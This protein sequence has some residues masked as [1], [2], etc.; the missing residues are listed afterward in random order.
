M[1]AILG[2]MMLGN[3]LILLVVSWFLNVAAGN[4][5]AFMAMLESPENLPLLKV[6]TGIN[7]IMMFIA[8]PIIYLRIFYA[9]KYREVLR[10][11]H[12]NPILL[13]LFPMALIAL[14]PI[15]G[16]L[17]FYMAQLDLPSFLDK[18][19][20]ES[21]ELVSKIITMNGPVDFAF[22]LI[23]VGVL[24]AIGE[25]LLFRGIIQQELAMHWKKNH[26]AIWTTAFIFAA[27]HFQVIGFIP[28]MMIGLILGYA[29][30]Y[31]KSLWLPVFLHFVN[32]SLTL[33]GAYISGAGLNQTEIVEKNIPLT[34]VVISFFI[35]GLLMY[36]IRSVSLQTYNLVAHDK[37]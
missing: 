3:Q 4:K 6:A 11:Q 22:N 24:P 12:F 1:I 31:G 8:G 25:E 19:D 29:L 15:M 13:W 2:I 17:T 20:E 32:N 5:D 10:L 28:K 23:L 9:E 37:K 7:H 27:F 14:Y 34:A 21:M 18:M 36:Y 30:H 35:F 33:W 16:Y 26:V